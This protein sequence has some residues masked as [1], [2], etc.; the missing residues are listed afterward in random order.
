MNELLIPKIQCQKVKNSKSKV[1]SQKKSICQSGM[2]S[3]RHFREK[4]KKV[5][6]KKVFLVKKSKR[7]KAKRQKVNISIFN[8]ERSDVHQNILMYYG[9]QHE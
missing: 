7:Q 1:K 3:L 5:Q 9:T 8:P 6:V 2:K 4:S